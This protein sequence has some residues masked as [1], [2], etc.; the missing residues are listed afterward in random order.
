MTY[1][2]A[3][4][5]DEQNQ[6]EYLTSIVSAWSNEN[7]HVCEMHTF[8]SAEA[9]LFAYEDDNAYDILL[10]DIE[11][12][13]I[14]G[15]DLAK[16]IRKKDQTVQI[17]FITGY[18]EYISEG[19]E[20]AALHYLMKP[21][22]KQKLFSVL[23][24]AAEKIKQNE[25]CLNLPLSGEMVRIPLHEIKYLDVHQNYVTVH[26]KA[27]YTVKRT[28]GEFEDLLDTRFTRVGRAMIINL[29]YISRV[30]KTDVY[31]SDGTVL[32]LPRGAY[33]PLNRAIIT[34]T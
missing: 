3:I 25:K 17:I 6:I 5:D 28:L 34:H 30:T 33:E 20:V 7:G 27:D 29:T 13:H 1:R 22:S 10:L 23:D 2:I 11:M 4:C 18:S 31:L 32:P 21:V 8:P 19:Y 24:R 16:S 15:V 26:A 12:K 14:T 9:F